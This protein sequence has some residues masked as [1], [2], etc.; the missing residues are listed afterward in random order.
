MGF[1]FF[2]FL[3]VKKPTIVK[4]RGGEREGERESRSDLDWTSVWVLEV[5]LKASQ[6]FN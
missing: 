4:L 5:E 2:F 3:G 6:R 1:F